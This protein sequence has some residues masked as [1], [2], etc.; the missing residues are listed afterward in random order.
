MK[1]WA[2]SDLHLSF[3]CDKPMD[4]FGDNWS[5]YVSKIKANWQKKVKSD[6]VVF[7]AGDISWALK[8]EDAIADLKFLGEL[9]GTKVIIK[10]NH[11]LWWSSIKKVREI[12]PE[13]VIA[14]QNDSVRFGNVLVCGT[15]GWACKEINKPYSSDDEKIFAREVIRLNLTLSDMQKKRTPQDKVVCLFHFP[16]FNSKREDNEFTQ[17]FEKFNV[18]VVVYGHLHGK[19]VRS[20]KLIVKN[21]IKYYL[22]STDQINH[23]P[24][25]ITF[26]TN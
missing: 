16:P 13:S 20:D 12:L 5:D 21:G 8:L 14:L 6:D 26:E 4:I 1:F 15:R 18:D 3:S 19:D 25:E 2:L 24:V 23:D 9:N 7:V 17:L 10:G 11:E 22:T